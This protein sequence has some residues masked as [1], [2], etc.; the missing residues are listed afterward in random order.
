M[1]GGMDLKLIYFSFEPY[2]QV[3]KRWNDIHTS[4]QIK[5]DQNVW[6][7]I[8]NIIVKIIWEFSK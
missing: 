6:T 4:I 2:L 8:S 7:N 1:G 3:L 5:H